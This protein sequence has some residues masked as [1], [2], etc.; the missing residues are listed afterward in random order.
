MLQLD[1]EQQRIMS[2]KLVAE[3]EALTRRSREDSED[4]VQGRILPFQ[5]FS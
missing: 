2:Q 1:V 4:K 3:G 5:H